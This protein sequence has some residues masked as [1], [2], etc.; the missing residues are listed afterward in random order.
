[1]TSIEQQSQ[2]YKNRKT[3]HPIRKLFLKKL[4]MI[5]SKSP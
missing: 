5:V 4:Q 2:I 1:M 3:L